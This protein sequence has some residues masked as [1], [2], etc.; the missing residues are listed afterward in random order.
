MKLRTCQDP[1]AAWP[2]R[3]GVQ[4]KAAIPANST[5]TQKARFGQKDKRL[6]FATMKAGLTEEDLEE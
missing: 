6:S 3:Q 4:E 2:A 1:S 5:G